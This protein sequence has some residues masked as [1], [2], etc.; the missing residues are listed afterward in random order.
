MSEQAHAGV[1]AE[2]EAAPTASTT[3][4]NRNLAAMLSY[5]LMWVTGIVMLLVEQRDRYVRFHA[6]QSVATFAALHVGIW[7]LVHMPGISFVGWLLIPVT[8]VLWIALMVKAFQGERLRLP[9]IGH[10][11]DLW[12]GR[13]D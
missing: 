4:V 11:A 9:V 8:L 2:P 10:L 3:G 12:V 1:S 5:L 7:M 6:Y 13:D